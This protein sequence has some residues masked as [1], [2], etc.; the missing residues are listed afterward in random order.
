[1][2]ITVV[3]TGYVGLVTGACFSEMGNNVT[4]VDIDADKI[5]NLKNGILPIFEPGLEEIVLNNYKHGFLKFSTSLK[6][7]MVDSQVLFI[8]VGTPPKED[9]SADLAHVLKVAEQIGQY[10]NSYCVVVDKSTVPVGTADLVRDKINSV[11]ADRKLEPDF[12]I[13]S[14]P[15]F[16]K[17]GDA[18]SDFMKPDRIVVG[19]ESDRAKKLMKALYSPF[20]RNHDKLIFMGIRD[21]EMTKYTANSLLATKISFMNEIAN[22]CEKLDVDVENVR[23]GIGSDSRIGYSFIYPGCGYGGSCFPKDVKALIKKSSS[24]GIEPKILNAVEERNESQKRVLFDKIIQRLGH[25]LTGKTIA[26]WGLAFKPGTDDMREATSVVLINQLIDA[27]AYI[28]TY[29]PVAMAE[30][31]HYFPKTYFD[32][33]QI[34]LCD[35]QYDAA[36]QTDALVL[37]TEWKSFRQPDFN[38]LKTIMNQTIIVD[39]RNQYDPEYVKEFGFEYHGIGRQ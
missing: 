32:S 38:K 25:N 19:V 36:D 8:A 34:V 4:C 29:D 18:I 13:V 1:M 24:V 7:A 17:E 14:N 23:K 5:Q 26:I 10:I 27:G 12:D 6:E 20:N 39:G 37:V 22:I 9:G 2:N 33:G 3:G 16:L 31:K 28:K 21:A 15:E 35:K 30:A 11:I